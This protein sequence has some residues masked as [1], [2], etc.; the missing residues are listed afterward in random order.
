MPWEETDEY[1]RSGHEDPSKYDSDSV[2]TIDISEEKGIKAVIGCP[3]GHF[4][5]GK[6]EV[7]TEVQSYLFAK[8]EGWSM[9]KAKEWFEKEQ[10]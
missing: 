9:S 10:K 5:S 8:E 2:R 1:I 7:G 3:K 4:K 6:C